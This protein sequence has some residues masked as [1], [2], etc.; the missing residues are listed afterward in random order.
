MWMQA[1]EADIN[2]RVH[3]T[4]SLRCV[5]H[6]ILQ[7]LRRSPRMSAGSERRAPHDLA[8]ELGRRRGAVIALVTLGK[9]ERG[10]SLGELRRA[11]GREADHLSDTDLR[12]MVTVGLLRRESAVGTWDLPDPGARY[13][14]SQVGRALATSLGAL[15]EALERPT[16]PWPN[17][18]PL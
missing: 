10:A 6:R 16:R 9:Y 2:C 12:W 3:D 8:A 7:L 13:N 15:A 14:L 5:V 17:V 1:S 4:L 11:V 18:H